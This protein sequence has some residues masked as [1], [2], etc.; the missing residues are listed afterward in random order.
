MS[1]QSPGEV[2]QLTV[3]VVI[4]AIIPDSVGWS[5]QSKLNTFGKFSFNQLAE[6]MEDFK[7]K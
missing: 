7:N 4:S 3:P 6:L 5:E 1:S 2:T